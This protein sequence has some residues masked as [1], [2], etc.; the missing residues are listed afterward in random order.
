[1]QAKETQ[2]NKKRLSQS[3][4]KVLEA[5]K[6][7]SPADGGIS[8][9]D[10]ADLCDLHRH[11]VRDSLRM[12]RRYGYIGWEDGNASGSPNVYKIIDLD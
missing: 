1:M 4:I 6:L 3:A 5:L 7:R 10:L 11:T 9:A 8:V 12:L 2:S